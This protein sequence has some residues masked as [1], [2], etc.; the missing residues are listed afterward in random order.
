M[1]PSTHYS[2]WEY[3][4]GSY[5]V[6]FPPSHQGYYWDSSQTVLMHGV[7]LSQVQDFALLFIVLHEFSVGPVLKFL[8][9]PLDWISATQFVTDFP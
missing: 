8:K 9:F 6:W 5:S 1:Q 2:R 3:A 4:V 7:V